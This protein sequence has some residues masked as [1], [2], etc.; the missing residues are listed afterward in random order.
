MNDGGGTIKGRNNNSCMEDAM[1]E[2][3]CY[4][5]QKRRKGELQD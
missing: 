3:M 2:T 1:E 4:D 5:K